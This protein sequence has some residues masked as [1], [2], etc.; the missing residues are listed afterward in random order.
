MYSQKSGKEADGAVD[1]QNYLGHKFSLDSSSFSNLVAFAFQ[2]GIGKISDTFQVG[3]I[4]RIPH[5]L[6]N[7]LNFNVGSD[8]CKFQEFG[9]EYFSKIRNSLGITFTEYSSSLAR[10]DA[11]D[12][13]H[14]HSTFRVVGL[15]ET[16]GKSLSWFIFSPDMMFCCKSLVKEE[17]AI[18]LDILASYEIYCFS[19]PETVLPHFLGDVISYTEISIRGYLI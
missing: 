15:D 10:L 6:I 2:E 3:K 4:E 11:N 8:L 7:V 1:P 12:E 18:L 9:S 17:A 13:A 14:L 16:A 5:K 19:N